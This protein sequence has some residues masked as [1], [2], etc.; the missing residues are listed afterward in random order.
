MLSANT[1]PGKRSC[2]PKVAS[3]SSSRRSWIAVSWASAFSLAAAALALAWDSVVAAATSAPPASSLNRSAGTVLDTNN[4][5]TGGPT[6]SPYFLA[7]WAMMASLISCPVMDSLL[8][9]VFCKP[10][11]FGR[12][13]EPG[14]STRQ[15]TEMR[16]PGALPSNKRSLLSGSKYLRDNNFLTSFMTSSF[17]LHRPTQDSLFFRRSS[18]CAEMAAFVSACL[19]D[20]DW[21]AETSSFMMNR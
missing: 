18:A 16:G 17:C 19:A 4:N 2:K 8:F 12:P 1:G 3:T 14:T 11:S 21:V 5:L 9:Q 7:V 10:T 13:F 20:K 6:V 15:R